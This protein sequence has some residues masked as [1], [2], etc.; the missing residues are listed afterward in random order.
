MYLNMEDYCLFVGTDTTGCVRIPAS[1]CGIFGFRPSHGAV[2]TIGVLP[3]AQ[4]LD[5]IGKMH[6]FVLF[7]AMIIKVLTFF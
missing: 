2:S 1:L 3:N 7:F 6:S 5:T 4:S